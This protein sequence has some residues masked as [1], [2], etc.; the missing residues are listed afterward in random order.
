MW[1]TEVSMN[2]D[3]KGYFALCASSQVLYSM[4]SEFKYVCSLMQ[5]FKLV[6]ERKVLVVLTECTWVGT[7]KTSPKGAGTPRASLLWGHTACSSH[8]LTRSATFHILRSSSVRKDLFKEFGFTFTGASREEGNTLLLLLSP[9][10]MNCLR[11][12]AILFIV[13]LIPCSTFLQK[14]GKGGNLML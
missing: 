4:R 8:V 1:I 3:P 9:P 12:S 13:A 6:P 2:H 5:I 14:E 7:Q 10:S 11:V